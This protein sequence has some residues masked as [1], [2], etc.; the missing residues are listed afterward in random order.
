[1]SSALNKIKQPEWES[2]FGPRGASMFLSGYRLLWRGSQ[3]F[4]LLSVAALIGEIVHR[5]GVTVGILVPSLCAY[6]VAGVV[7]IRAIVLASREI[8]RFN[9]L[10][11][12]L[13]RKLSKNQMFDSDAFDS[14]LKAERSAGHVAKG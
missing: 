6:V 10:D 14:W 4:L 13:V 5:P 9:G 12:H 8:Y 1:M 11:P 3:G 2:R 7:A